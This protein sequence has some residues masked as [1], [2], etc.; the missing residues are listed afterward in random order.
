MYSGR[1]TITF[2]TSVRVK[3]K[4]ELATHMLI[5]QLCKTHLEFT[6]RRPFDLEFGTLRCSD[7]KSK[8]SGKYAEPTMKNLPY[9]LKKE[10]FRF[11]SGRNEDILRF[12]YV[13]KGVHG[14]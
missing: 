9:E 2:R 8:N 6:G 13:C 14:W 10:I 7:Y 4:V 5:V 11:A 12:L 1:L 3:K